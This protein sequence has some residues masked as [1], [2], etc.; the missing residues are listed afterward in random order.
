LDALEAAGLEEHD[1]ERREDALEG[2]GYMDSAG[3]RRL[4][5]YIAAAQRLRDRAFEK[6]E[7]LQEQRLRDQVK[8]RRIDDDDDL[9]DDDDDDDRDD[10][11]TVVEASPRRGLYRAQERVA[12]WAPTNDLIAR[13]AAPFAMKIDPTPT[14]VALV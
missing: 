1:Q 6:L 2:F 14:L 3:F 4:Y 11:D 13:A 10:D 9:D 8:A 5:R 7:K 12:D